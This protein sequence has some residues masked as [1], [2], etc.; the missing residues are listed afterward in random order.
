MAPN[1]QTTASNEASGNGS[2]MASAC[3]HSTGRLVPTRAARSSMAGLRSVATTGTEGGRAC[4]SWRVT[5][6]VPA[7]ISSTE[8]GCL[9]ATRAARSSA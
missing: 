4:A 2:C 8:P 1:W 7:A 5:T 9:A 3:C 6:P